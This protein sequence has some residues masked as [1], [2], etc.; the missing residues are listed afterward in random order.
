MKAGKVFKKN[1]T[2]KL[3]FWL[4]PVLYLLA[5]VVNAYVLAS[6]QALTIGI[7]LFLFM[8]LSVFF[9]I[10]NSQF[11]LAKDSVANVLFVEDVISRKVSKSFLVW[12]P[13]VLIGALL[14]M[15]S[16]IVISSIAMWLSAFVFILSNSKEFNMI[17]PG[18]LGNAIKKG[19][20]MEFYDEKHDNYSSYVG[21]VNP[22]TG[23]PLVSGPYDSSG[24]YYGTSNINKN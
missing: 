7:T 21:M 2:W 18:A 16:F 24:S 12:F 14:G 13:L 22:A 8:N 4:M 23:L 20:T 6:P 15:L 5:W 1:M 19:A 10:F 3:K 17:S 11:N 9:I